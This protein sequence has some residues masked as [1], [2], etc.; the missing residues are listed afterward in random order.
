MESYI[1]AARFLK[2]LSSPDRSIQPKPIQFICG[3]HKLAADIYKPSKSSQGV[4]LFV[5]G[6]TPFG[7]RDPRMMDLG[8]VAAQLRYTGIIPSYPMISKGL[9]DPASIDNVI[10]T[11]NAIVTD[12]TMCPSGK[13]AIFTASFSG[14]ICIRAV[15]QESIRDVVSTMLIVGGCNNPINSFAQIMQNPYADKYAKL[16]LLKNLAKQDLENDIVL[17]RALSCAIEDEY[18]KSGKSDAYK[19]YLQYLDLD[20]RERVIDFIEPVLRGARNPLIEYDKQQK[21]I[22][23]AFM[24]WLDIKNI[25]CKVALVHSESDNVISSEESKAL[26]KELQANSVDSRL[27]ISPLL[28]HTDLKFKL[29]YV[30]GAVRLYA[31]FHYFLSAIGDN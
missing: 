17:E 8:R 30:V 5:H 23:H 27:L 14:S 2:S 15:S 7:Y 31:F 21:A 22:H 12:T 24:R 11:I 10:D 6:M 4:I 29:S 28:D 3:D 25:R 20:D 16:L 13:L 18:L 9:I 26:F 1:K 19:S